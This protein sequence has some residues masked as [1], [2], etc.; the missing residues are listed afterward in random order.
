MLVPAGGAEKTLRHDKI[1]CDDT[2]PCVGCRRRGLGADACI[3]GCEP[4]RRARLRCDGGA[5]CARCMARGYACVGEPPA[6]VG[7]SVEARKFPG[8]LRPIAPVA[9]EHPPRKAKLPCKACRKD[10]QKCEDHRPCGR[11]VLRGTA[12]E[13]VGRGPKMISVRCESC[14]ATNKRCEDAR[15]CQFCIARGCAC[16][17]PPRKGRGQGTRVKA[18][19]INCR[20]EKIRCDGSR[21]AMK[22]P[23]RDERQS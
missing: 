5:P 17:D 22:L 7:V 18:A 2:R 12:C 23:L 15:P 4:C 14:R 3:D 10:N 1:R 13:R 20:N 19:C 21:W 16:I 8:A 9:T 6:G 11:C